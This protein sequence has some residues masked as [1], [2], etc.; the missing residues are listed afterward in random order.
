MPT[1]RQ[2]R[3]AFVA[4]HRITHVHV[5][6][7]HMHHR[8]NV[9]AMLRTCEA[10][11]IHHVHLV[12]EERFQAAKGPAKGSHHWLNLH[13]HETVEEAIAWVKDHGLA[14]WVADFAEPP[15]EPADVPL[16]QPV[17]VWMGAELVGVSDKAREAADGVIT[18]GMY[19]MSQSLNVSAAAGMTLH[20]LTSRVRRELGPEALL[21]PLV[22]KE[23]VAGWLQRDVETLPMVEAERQATE[24]LGQVLRRE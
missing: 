11:G 4:A 6:L 9:S 15:V 7:E 8:H 14:L 19:G 22:A 17:A 3:L 18:I 10:L 13:H 16:Q 23:M 5:V 24:L 12:G 2:E 1:R 21:D 20:V